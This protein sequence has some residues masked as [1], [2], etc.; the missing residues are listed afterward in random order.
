[1]KINVKQTLMLNKIYVANVL[2]VLNLIRLV[3]KLTCSSINV[4]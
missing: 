2:N 1:M 4:I 3:Q